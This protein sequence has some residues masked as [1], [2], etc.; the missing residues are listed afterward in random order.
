MRANIK[1]ALLSMLA[2]TDFIVIKAAATCVA[3]IAVIELPAGQWPLFIETLTKNAESQDLNVR[4][5]S[6]QTLGFICEDIDPASINP[7]DMNSILF[8]VLS[9]IIPQE[10]TLARIAMKAFARAAPITT[11]NFPD[12]GQKN[13]IM[14]KMF[15]AG[16]IEDEEVLTSLMEAMNDIVRVNYDYMYEFIETIGNLTM[17]LI[18]SEHEK[19]ATL[20]VEV[21]TTLADVE[22]QRKQKN[23]NCL[24]IISGCYESIIQII[25]QG[26]GKFEMST[27]DEAL[28]E[29]PENNISISAGLTL[30]SISRVAGNL[31]LQPVLDF[32]HPK[33]SS[34]NWGDRYIGMIA[35]GSIIDG[36]DPNQICSIIAEAYSAIIEM[37]NDPVPKV[38]QTVSFVFYKLSEFVPQLIF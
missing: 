35:F 32:I 34:A 25:F 17:K 33:L 5:A 24:N 16:N 13:F 2:N 28:D 7:V 19:P 3:A 26:F 21:W 10:L 4:L 11:K 22:L 15:E 38:R 1:E 31:V 37:I 27:Q 18:S 36:P 6:I 30:E 20:A 12:V 29:M 8:A 14:Q 23:G 9:N